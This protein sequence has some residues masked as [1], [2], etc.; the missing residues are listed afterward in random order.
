RPSAVSAS[1]G[2]VVTIRGSGFVNGTAVSIGGKSA[3]VSF[4]DV[5]TLS[6]TTPS[7]TPGPQK[8]AVSNRDGETVS[9]DAAF[10]AN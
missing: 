1:G 7:L 9:L 2:A 5:N 6:V 3:T 4:K 8:I 10:T